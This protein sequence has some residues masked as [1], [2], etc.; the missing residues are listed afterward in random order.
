MGSVADGKASVRAE[1]LTTRLRA[2]AAVFVAVVESVDHDR[3]SRVPSPGV[4]SIGKDVEH[5]AEAAIYHQWIVRTTI[6]QKVPARRP[7]IER[8]RMT[9]ELAPHEA[10]ELV[11]RRTEE[12]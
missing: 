4:W 3:W 7:A 5:V 6:R 10:I 1:A 11:G 12:G 8:N 2:A 9:T